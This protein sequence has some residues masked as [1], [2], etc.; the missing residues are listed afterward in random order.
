MSDASLL[1]LATKVLKKWDR[2]WEKPGT[3][4]PKPSQ[5]H[6]SPRDKKSEQDQYDNPFV[7]LSQP[8]GVGHWDK[9]QNLGQ[10]LGNSW[11]KALAALETRCP[12]F[13]EAERW[14]QC[15]DDAHQFLGEWGDQAAALGWGADDLFGLH[16]PPPSPHP[17]YCRLS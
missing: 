3:S 12:D 2:A 15:V 8:L 17:S 10:T 14:H 5:S 13:I 11:D 7:P 16:D 9:P 1:E 6:N 4:R